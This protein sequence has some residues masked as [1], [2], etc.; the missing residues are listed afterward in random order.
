MPGSQIVGRREDKPSGNKTRVI[1]KSWW[2]RKKKKC[3]LSPQPPALFETVFTSFCTLLLGAWNGL[4][5]SWRFDCICHLSGGNIISVD[6]LTK[7][8][9]YIKIDELLSVNRHFKLLY[10]SAWDDTPHYTRVHKLD[11]F[12]PWLDER[13]MWWSSPICDKRDGDVLW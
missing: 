12:R 6:N 3:L 10:T 1:W 5:H 4:G 7:C 13:F 11:C 2:W 8:S 9:F